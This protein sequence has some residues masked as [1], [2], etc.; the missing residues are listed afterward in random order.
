MTLKDGKHNSSFLSFLYSFRTVI[1]FPPFFHHFPIPFNCLSYYHPSSLFS[2][3]S[4][5]LQQFSNLFFYSPSFPSLIFLSHP[6]VTPPPTSSQ[7]NIGFSLSL[8]GTGCYLYA[9][10]STAVLF[11]QNT[12]LSVFLSWVLFS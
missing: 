4:F 8:K 2:S 7:L 11:K 10:V 5:I 1:S 12:F 3:L 9:Q 6:A